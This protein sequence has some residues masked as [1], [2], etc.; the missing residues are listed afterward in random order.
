M[1]TDSQDNNNVTQVDWWS[2][3]SLF[4]G[5]FVLSAGYLYIVFSSSILLPFASHDDL[6][7]FLFDD[8]SIMCQS[9]PYG[10]LS[11]SDWSLADLLTCLLA[12]YVRQM[13]DLNF[14]R[15]ITTVVLAAG[16]AGLAVT[17]NNLKLSRGVS[18]ALSAAIFTLPGFLTHNLTA[19]AVPLPVSFVFAAASHTLIEKV[20]PANLRT[21]PLGFKTTALGILS[22]VFLMASADFYKLG[23]IFFWV[24][25][26]AML[27]FKDMDEWPDTRLRFLRD[28]VLF[29]TAGL[30]YFLFYHFIIPQISDW[31]P[32]FNQGGNDAFALTIDFASR[33]RLLA[34]KL[35]IKALNLW[36]IYPNKYLAVAVLTFILFGVLVAVFGYFFKARKFEELPQRMRYAAQ[37]VATVVVVIVITNSAALAGFGGFESFRALISYQ[38]VLVILLFWALTRIASYLPEEYRQAVVPVGAVLMM[39]AGG[40]LGQRHVF[41]TSI[42]Q[43]IARSYIRVHITPRL[44]HLRAVHFILLSNV[45]R[46]YTNFPIVPVVD[47]F[48]LHH[49]EY[50]YAEIVRSILIDHRDKLIS[51][52]A[53]SVALV[54]YDKQKQGFENF[55]GTIVTTSKLGE[56]IHAPPYAT[57]IDM[58]DLMFPPLA[59]KHPVRVATTGSGTASASTEGALKLV[60]GIIEPTSMWDA[61][62]SGGWWKYDFGAGVTKAIAKYVMYGWDAAS[63]APKT[64]TFEG[65]NNNVN[66]TILDTQKNV[67]WA[68]GEAKMFLISKP[69]AYRYYRL[70]IAAAGKGGSARLL[71][72]K[73]LELPM[74]P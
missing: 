42:N 3:A 61:G 30:V 71:E 35:S 62:P 33:F 1:S 36:N 9:H 58:N 63:N 38:A 74:V 50:G 59:P 7:L 52:D 56:P 70:N 39:L 20:S 21:R 37:Y 12:K 25:T 60:D 64:W 4:I 45:N 10:F 41:D 6:G 46:S 11:G 49:E 65:S 54:D 19:M 14:I 66:W 51:K 43:H 57:V 68:D 55:P 26:A 8:R 22:L 17:L 27:L 31:H 47:D 34:G 69:V 23:T 15:T 53:I 40:I 67:V 72:L 44:D 32:K 24:P 18:F 5:F 48:N 16:M 73:L 13:I 2:Q 29:V 28:C